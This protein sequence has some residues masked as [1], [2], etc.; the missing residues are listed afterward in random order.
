MNKTFKLTATA[1]ALTLAGS[2]AALGG[3][4]SDANPAVTARVNVMEL[5]GFHLG[6]LGGMA[7]GKVDY[8]AAAAS[9]AANNLLALA[10]LD[11][12]AWWPAGTDNAS[13]EGTRALPKIWEDFEGVSAKGQAFGE[14]T[15]N[16]ASVAGDGL[17][18][19]QGAIGPVGRS[20]GGC[21]R[22]YRAP[23]N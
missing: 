3:G 2:F 7:E 9:A 18:A 5:Y 16:L 11:Q 6:I 4:H 22:E 1:L 8:D 21:H 17:E 14:A 23:R 13:I 10:S 20:C 19:L 12:S 15:A